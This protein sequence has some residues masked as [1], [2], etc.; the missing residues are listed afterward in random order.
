M[1]RVLPFLVLL[2]LLWLLAGAFYGGDLGKTRDD[3]TWAVNDPATGAADAV[4]LWRLPLFWRPASLVLVR[5]LV[6][7][8]WDAP[9]IANLLTALAHLSLVLVFWRWLR[10]LGCGAAA[11]ASAMLFVA[12][13][14]AYDVMHWP[15][16]MPTALSAIVAIVAARLALGSTGE[17]RAARRLAGI[18]ALA[19]LCCCLNEQAAAC[20]AA[21]VVVPLLQRRRS[22]IG[23]A[24]AIGLPC[25]AYV[26]LTMMTAP[27]NHRGGVGTLVDPSDWGPRAISALASSADQLMGERGRHLLLGGL[28]TAWPALGAWGVALVA[29]AVLAGVWWSLARR[30]DADGERGHWP[31]AA[32]GIAWAAL[33]LTPF[34]VVRT[35][36]IEARHLYLPLLGV[37]LAASISAARIPAPALVAIG[38]RLLVAAAALAMAISLVG[39]Q[40]TLRVRAQMDMEDAAAIVAAHPG[41]PGGAVILIARQAW[42]QADTGLRRYDMRFWS[43]WQMDH[44]A[45]AVVRHAYGRSDLFA[46]NRF[47][48]NNITAADVSPEG[49]RVG[50]SKGPAWDGGRVPPVLISWDRVRALTIDGQGRVRPVSALRFEGDGGFVQPLQVDAAAPLAP[51]EYTVRLR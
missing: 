35:G 38:G 14:I 51:A 36:P 17:E 10:K 2:L 40:T 34:I 9:W 31:V 4:D 47:A 15:A 45:T 20:L 44:M 39:I 50:L 5:H 41:P 28:E 27:P 6:S 25:V 7:L 18:A 30:P 21:V 46:K 8:T 26:T 12:L 43:A 48:A 1:R 33:G 11:D 32:A 16:A 42:R 13:P 23:V 19:F 22:A 3:Y 37:L 49:W 29:A 24:L